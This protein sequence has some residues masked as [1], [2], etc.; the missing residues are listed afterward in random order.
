MGE[1]TNIE[2]TDATWNC[3]Q[4]CHKI[5]FG[6]LNCYMYREK[7]RYGQNPNIVIRSSDKTFNAPLKWENPKYIIVCSWSDFFM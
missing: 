4:G 3:W 6:C 2:W 5:S 7:K 1:K